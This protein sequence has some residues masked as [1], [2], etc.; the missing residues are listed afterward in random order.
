MSMRVRL[1]WRIGWTVRVR[2]VLVM[3]MS[4][5]VFDGLVFMRMLVQFGYV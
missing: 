3:D 1:A 2:V 4:V 5:F